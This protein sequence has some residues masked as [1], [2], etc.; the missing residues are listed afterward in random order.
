VLTQMDDD[1]KEFVIV[2]ASRSN[3]N[4][5]AQYSLYEGEY[6]AAIWAIVHFRYYL[7]MSFC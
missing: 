4:V 5:E 1:G 6:L 2:Y 7:V 3:N